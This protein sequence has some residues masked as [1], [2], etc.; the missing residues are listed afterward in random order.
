MIPKLIMLV[1][2]STFY[3]LI[4]RDVAFRKDVSRAIWIPTLWV[5]I[6]ASRPLSTWFNF[7][8]GDDT[9][10][11][12]PLDRMGFFVLIAAAW[13]TLN[14]RRY[15][16]ST[17]ISGN[18]PVF[19]FYGFLFISIVWANSPFVS[20]KRWF[21]EFGN[22]IVLLVILTEKDPQQAC[23]AVFVRCAYV[24]MPLSVVFIRYFPDLGRRYNIHSGEMEAIGV[25]FQKNSLGAMVLVCGLVI[26]WDWFERSRPGKDRMGKFDRYLPVFLLSCGG[27]LLHLC[28]SKT[29]ITCL[30][31]GSFILAA[32]RL[33]LMRRHIGALG[34]C[35]L[36][37][38]VLFFVLDSL[39]GI[40]E[41]L[42]AGLGR[43]ATLTGRTDVW[44]ELFKL[45][46]DPI[47]GTGF[48][49]FWDDRQYRAK[50]PDWVAFSAHNGYIEIFLAGGFVGIFALVI[51]LLGTGY[52]INRSLSW[53]G[54]FCRG[55]F[56]CILSGVAC[57][58]F[59][60]QF[61]LH[62]PA[63]FPLFGLGNRLCQDQ[64][65]AA[66]VRHGLWPVATGGAWIL[67]QGRAGACLLT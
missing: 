56:C 28:D 24:L 1:S 58:C 45:H 20:F 14:R 8:G 2:L 66:A 19:V 55:P 27:Y 21:K 9:M 35:A 67:W 49:S 50:L 30:C 17:L 23:R 18:W 31:I 42:V 52:R 5:A 38:L 46:T 64:T 6:I 43:D 51:M 60:I 40:K 4:K 34:L 12:S 57:Q 10:E 47:L 59:R 41:D 26:V 15:D 29:S 36:A 25:T 54:D 11:G 61:C 37:A 48:M 62:D 13:I 7:G 32:T 33:P 44:R 63:R 16:W 39:F 65:R 22:I 53:G 3:W